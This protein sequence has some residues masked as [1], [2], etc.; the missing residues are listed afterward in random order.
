MPEYIEEA[1]DLEPV[2][3]VI[4]EVVSPLH[5]TEQYLNKSGLK[6]T[7]DPT[8][9]DDIPTELLETPP[10][11]PQPQPQPQPQQSI[12]STSNYS[13]NI[14]SEDTDNQY[15]SRNSNNP[16][17]TA[18]INKDYEYNDKPI[19][20]S[21]NVHINKY[22]NNSN[23]NNHGIQRKDSYS[24]GPDDDEDDYY[25]G[26]YKYRSDD[27]DDYDY[28]PPGEADYVRPSGDG[29]GSDKYDSEPIIFADSESKKCFL[30]KPCPIKYGVVQC[31]IE[32]TKQ[33]FRGNSCQYDVYLRD[34]KY[35]FIFY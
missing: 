1:K 3:P 8:V 27:E 19:A 10:R 17:R 13:S 21:P 31:Y 9:G 28:T 23:N 11:Y 22:P 14:I 4:R 18:M 6:A 32:R 2:R 25:A 20:G 5:P 26:E 33:G 7:Y 35:N 30:T 12:Q 16:N 15:N 24:P 34:G 29:E